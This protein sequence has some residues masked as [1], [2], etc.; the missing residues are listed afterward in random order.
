MMDLYC[1]RLGP[2]LWAEPINASSNLTFFIAAWAIWHLAQVRQTLSRSVWLLIALVVA[3][4]T[5]SLL[6]HTFATS[7]ARFLE[8]SPILIFK[9]LFLWIYSRQI[10]GMGCGSSVI[11][12]LGFVVVAHFGAQF[13]HVLNGSVRYAPALLLLLGMGF[14]HH[15][16]GKKER[17]LL[18]VAV[19]VL[20]LSLVFRTIDNGVCPYF[21]PG[22]HFLWHLL[23]SVVLYFLLRGVVV[24]LPR[25]EA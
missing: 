11:L 22:T 19:G 23:N 17:G 4:G 13:P 1:E 5:G 21:T 6:F 3:I 14:Y 18:L 25:A 7:W 9:L 10:A 8:L 20:S 16:R 24:N 2:G 15:L 12:C